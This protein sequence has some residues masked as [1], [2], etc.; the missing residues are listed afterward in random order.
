M[1]KKRKFSLLKTVDNNVAIPN[2]LSTY[3]KMYFALKE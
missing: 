2:Q 3:K 1:V